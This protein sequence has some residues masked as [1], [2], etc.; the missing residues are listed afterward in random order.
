MI[1]KKDI[2]IKKGNKIM[3]EK[4]IYR[5]RI[6]LDTSEDVAEFTKIC[7]TIPSEVIVKGKDENG[8][9]WLLS[10]KSLFCSLIMTAK[11]QHRKHTA[12]DVDW[13]TVYVECEE[14]I[15]SLIEKFAI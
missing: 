5:T 2:T 15:Y 11:L 7:S 3:E 13:N 14:D 1:N 10:A 9:E 8:S 6:E 4:K 12:H